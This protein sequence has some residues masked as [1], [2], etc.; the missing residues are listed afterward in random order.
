MI[1]RCLV[2]G[3]NGFIGK[4]IIF[5]L[6]NNGYFVVV[7][8]IAQKNNKEAV[9]EHENLHY[10]EGDIN[11]TTYLVEKIHNIDYVIWLIHTTVPATS[12]YNIEFDLLSNIPPLVRF[13]QQIKQISSIKKI[14]YLSS[15]GTVYGNPKEFIPI[16][17]SFEKNPISSYGLT[18]LVAE[19]YLTFLTKNSNISNKFLE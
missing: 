13:V 19:E 11:N 14:I 12:M 3:G 2:L 7:F 17:E 16:E 5:E 9:I 6:L 15:G 18:K 10:I 8:D 4:N 1:K